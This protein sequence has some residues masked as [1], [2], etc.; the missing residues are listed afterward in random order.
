[1]F[2]KLSFAAAAATLAAMGLASAA[3][4]PSKKSVPV[5]AA[6]EASAIHGYMNIGYAN[7][8]VTGGGVPLYAA[9][10]TPAL[11]QTELGLSIDLYKSKTG[12]IN[13]V[14]VFGGV[15]A[16]SWSN[17]PAGKAHMQEYDWWAGAAVG[18]ADYYKLSVQS[19]QFQIE[20]SKVEK[21]LTAT[22]SYDDAHLGLPIAL[23]PSVTLFY[24]AD[25]GVPAM[26]YGKTNTYRIDLAVAPGYSFQKSAGLPLSISVPTSISFGPKDMYY[27][28]GSTGCGAGSAVCSTSTFQMFST[29]LQ[30]KYDLGQV[31]PKKFGAWSLKAGVQHYQFLSD[32]IK[33]N[34]GV[35][36]SAAKSNST[37]ISAG[38]GVSF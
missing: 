1:M 24:V 35:A 25:G 37:V 7:G 32:A 2:C 27:V 36:M 20:P 5:A 6:E 22:L 34:Q 3:D 18:F 21:N 10:H 16:E 30:A 31:V 17:A 28:A 4:L 8:R 14:S 9:Y 19:L 26:L 12:L 11:L 29:G 38:L 33:A 13:S 15:W 23:N